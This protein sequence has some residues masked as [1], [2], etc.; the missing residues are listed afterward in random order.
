MA[1]V[2]KDMCLINGLAIGVNSMTTLRDFVMPE[3]I[4]Y[5]QRVSI[6]YMGLSNSLCIT[7]VIVLIG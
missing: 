3:G 6:L 1:I 4:I 5:D 7:R 2:S